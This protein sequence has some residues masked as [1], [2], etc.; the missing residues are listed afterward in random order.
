MEL[1]ASSPLMAKSD[2]CR[3]LRKE[4]R[5]ALSHSDSIRN[6]ICNLVVDALDAGAAD[7]NGDL[8]ILTAGDVIAARLEFANPAFGNAGT[9][10]VGQATAN[11]IE[12]DDN[13][14]GGIVTKFIMRNRDNVGVI[15]GSVAPVGGDLS[16]SAT[17][18]VGDVISIE[19]GDLIYEATP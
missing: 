3:S 18:G 17:I 2:L 19:D 9:P 16:G 12:E 14:V 11:S 7:P 8:V 15:F 6:A 10:G 4:E 1:Y 5:M 13:A